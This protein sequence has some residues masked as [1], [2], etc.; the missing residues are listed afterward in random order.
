MACSMIVGY[1]ES[2]LGTPHGI[3]VLYL[4]IERQRGKQLVLYGGAAAHG[5]LFIHLLMT[6]HGRLIIY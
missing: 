3:T 4:F 2:W 6:I 5:S 1:I